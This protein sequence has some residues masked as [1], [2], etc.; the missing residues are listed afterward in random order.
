M[1]A[2]PHRAFLLAVAAVCL[3]GRAVL[4]WRQQT[5]HACAPATVCFSPATRGATMVG[6][7]LGLAP[8]YL[9]HAY[10]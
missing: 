9:G 1:L 3:G 7:L 5:A 6:L 8:L 4:L 2:A 10:A